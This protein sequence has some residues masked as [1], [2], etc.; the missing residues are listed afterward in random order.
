MSKVNGHL[1]KIWKDILVEVEK[2]VES[3]VFNTYFKESDI[4]KITDNK[5]VL[6]KVENN[7]HGKPNSPFQ[8]WCTR[9]SIE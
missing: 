2:D 7:L 4:Y 6:L 1:N 3:I 8:G 5:K 9:K